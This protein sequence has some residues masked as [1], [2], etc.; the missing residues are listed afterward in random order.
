[1][2]RRSF[3]LSALALALCPQSSEAGQAGALDKL[4]DG[5]DAVNGPA[6]AVQVLKRGK[7]VYRHTS[8]LADI[9]TRQAAHANTC[10]RL[11]SMTKAFTAMA[12]LQLVDRKQ[13]RFE[14]PLP[15]IFPGFPG[16]G[17]NITVLD[18]LRHTS[19]LPDFASLLPET[20]TGQVKDDDVLRMLKA[21][22]SGVFPPGERFEY[23]NSGYIL[24]GLAVAKASGMPFGAFLRKNIFDPAGMNTAIVYDGETTP[25]PERAFGYTK[26]DETY[27]R[28]DQSTTSATQG[29]GGIYASLED[30]AGWEAALVHGRLVSPAL[31]TMA[32]S[33]GRLPNGMETGYGFGWFIDKVNGHP[34]YW[35]GGGTAGFHN[36]FVRLPETGISVQVLMNH[37]D[38]SPELAATRLVWQLAPEFRPA[39]PSVKPLTSAQLDAFQGYYDFRGTLTAIQN[40]GGKLAWLGLDA[41]PVMLLPEDAGTFF[42]ESREIN[43]DRNWRLRFEG[44]GIVSQISYLV[45]SRVVFTLPALGA[46]CSTLAAGRRAVN[47]PDP[48]VARVEAWLAGAPGSAATDLTPPQ[49]LTGKSVR[50]LEAMQVAA[51][52]DRN[53]RTVAAI[54]KFAVGTG[55]DTRWLVVSTDTTG[56]ILSADVPEV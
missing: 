2:D 46:L 8:G 24:L 37:D 25:I 51:P 34:R 40:R 28:N 20:F 31:Q 17:Q 6:M 32:F 47:G 27:V 21:R 12:I 13:L 53:G 44:Q 48:F 10:F 4:L 45:D 36:H 26:H 11:A 49:G 35:H 30:M 16:Y 42:Y 33:P 3:T 7:V 52:I 15:E 19:G 50:M 55:T 43:P 23:S 56:A 54:Y 29:D 18:L 14:T 41:K 39:E 38:A 9:E 1:M 22:D 5:F